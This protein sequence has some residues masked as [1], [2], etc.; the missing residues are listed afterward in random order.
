MPVL[1]H[2]EYDIAKRWYVEFYL[3]G[4]RYQISN[5]KKYGIIGDG[6]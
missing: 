5:G 6:N 2:Y 3:N 1:R 4:K